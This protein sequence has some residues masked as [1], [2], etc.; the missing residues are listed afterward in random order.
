MN[1]LHYLLEANLYLAIFYAVY[2]LFLRNDTHYALSRIYLLATAAISFV[3]PL[4]QL[5]FLKPAEPQL[6]SV[7]LIAPPHSSI[8]S[9]NTTAIEPVNFTW[10]DGLIYAYLLGVTIL[11][12]IF[13]IKIYQLFKLTRATNAEIDA[14]YKLIYVD[15]SNTAFSFFNFLFIGT[16]ATG[17]DT[18]I[19]HELVHIRQKHSA[20]IVFVEL[21]KI[22]NWFNPFVYLVQHSLKA[23]HE[24]IADEQTAM[25]E[26]DAL[27]YS[28]FLV[29]NAYGLSGSSVTHSFFNYN[30]LKKRII[31]L[32]QQRSGNLARLKYLLAAPICGGLL[33]ASTLAFSKNYGFIDI[34]PHRINKDNKSPQV[35]EPVNRLLV[36][37][38][39][40]SVITDKFSHQY[41]NG[42]VKYYTAR[43][44]SNKAIEDLKKEGVVVNII[45][46]DEVDTPK[47]V[48]FIANNNVTNYNNAYTTT[49]GYDVV[50]DIHN[51]NGVISKKVVITEKD[52]SKH[53]Y[54]DEKV[55]ISERKMLLDKYG[56][57][58]P[59]G[60]LMTVK[61]L[62]PPPPSAP[63]A[64]KLTLAPPTVHVRPTFT[65]TGYLY[66]EDGY[67]INGKTDFRVIMV[68]KNGEQKAFFKSKAS[69]ADLK[70]LREKYGYTF[71]VMEIYTKLPPPPPTVVPIAPVK[72]MPPPPP[73]APIKT[74]KL[75][76]LLPPIPGFFTKSGK[77]C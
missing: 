70:L 61:L 38:H 3:I 45:S 56:Y 69:P 27:A 15:D 76:P 32:N 37:Q 68:E 40:V 52:G 59:S 1:W 48:H 34:A 66:E 55:S 41:A 19:Q 71:P 60:K 9:S 67:T 62:P 21:L 65:K 13:S 46:G 25:A 5:G 43:N 58:F 74:T 30:L 39:G 16:K 63:S 29:N 2:Y 20:D 33:C 42:S 64:K 24:Y 36:T 12:I 51:H 26:S 50:E 75:L 17:A 31:M 10:Q 35:A 77:A 7:T 72:R 22:I 8:V 23:I 4:L 11:L 44:L 49:K 73:V 14:P 54:Y 18:I 6:I 28:T 47:H 53:T 57:K